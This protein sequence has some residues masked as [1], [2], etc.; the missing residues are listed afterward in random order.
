VISSSAGLVVCSANVFDSWHI[1]ATVVEIPFDAMEDVN[2]E[3]EAVI[4]VAVV[5]VG[6][7]NDDVDDGRPDIRDRVFDDVN[8]DFVA[9]VNDETYRHDEYNDDTPNNHSQKMDDM[10]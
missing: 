4:M 8:D 5:V 1:S 9:I 7:D 6:C 2:G 3:D 10:M